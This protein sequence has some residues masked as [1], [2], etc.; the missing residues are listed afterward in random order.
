M[1]CP[2]VKNVDGV[3]ETAMN[4]EPLFEE[5]LPTLDN[6]HLII[7]NSQHLEGSVGSTV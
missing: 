3:D 7:L 5:R 4:L 2:V 1:I 6:I